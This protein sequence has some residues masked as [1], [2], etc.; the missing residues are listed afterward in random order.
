MA[1]GQIKTGSICRSERMSRYNKPLKIKA[2]LGRVDIFGNAWPEVACTTSSHQ[3][4]VEVKI[5]NRPTEDCLFCRMGK[6]EADHVQV[7][8]DREVL[9]I[10]DLYPATPG[11]MLVM[12]KKHIET[13]YEIPVDLGARIMATTIML[14]KVIKEKLSPDGLNL[15]QSNEIKAGQTVAHFHLHI[16]PRYQGDPVILQFGHGSAPE[17]VAELKRIASLVK[18]GLRLKSR[19]TA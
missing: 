15:I 4:K 5:M 3:L 6:H 2:E 12:P 16:V 13:L 1:G 7:L 10:L 9:A 19:A 11:H 14:A 17:R 18:S 8:E